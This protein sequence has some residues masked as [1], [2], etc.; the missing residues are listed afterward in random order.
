MN[1]PGVV[2]HFDVAVRRFEEP[3]EI[4][5]RILLRNLEPDVIARAHVPRG[6]IVPTREWPPVGSFASIASSSAALDNETAGIEDAQDS[7]R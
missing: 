6:T 5:G 7:Y 2:R 4:L 1:R 3:A